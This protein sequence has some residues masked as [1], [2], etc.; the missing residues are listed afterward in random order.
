MIRFDVFGFELSV[1]FGFLFVISLLSLI[2]SPSLGFIAAASCVIHELGHCFAAVILG[3]RIK[4]V[5]FWA[6][7]IKM[8]REERILSL[9]NDFIILLSGPVF[10]FVFAAL[11]GVCS[12]YSVA[13]VNLALGIFNLLPYRSLDG[14]CIIRAFFE[15]HNI[16]SEPL[17]KIS[18]LTAGLLI[19]AVFF[20]AG[21][22]NL[23][24]YATIVLLTAGEF[25]E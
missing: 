3:V 24:A 14:G 12:M 18:A 2:D 15:Y 22:T 23:T 25:M 9:G 1:T 7:G 8:V 16:Y 17:L 4:G 10:N 11:Y 20:C 21:N 13:A 6:G 19:C 5:K